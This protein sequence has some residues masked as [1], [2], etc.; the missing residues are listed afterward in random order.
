MIGEPLPHDSAHLHVT[1]QALY[2]DDIPMPANALHAAFGI[3]TVAHARITTVDLEAV[4]ASAGVV[5]MAVAADV[6]G[7]NN[8]GGAV[9]DD[10]IFADGLVQYAGQPVF[11]VAATSYALARKAVRRARI[12]YDELPAILDIRAALAAESYVLP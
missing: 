5:A 12:T 9:H 1:G 2:C 3:S 4:A 11:A 10:P 8:Y 7:E 6:P